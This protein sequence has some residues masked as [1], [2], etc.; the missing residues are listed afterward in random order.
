MSTY[1]ENQAARERIAGKAAQD[2]F[3]RRQTREFDLAAQ[4]TRMKYERPSFVVVTSSD[5]FRAGYDQIRWS[6]ESKELV[7]E[8]VN[9][10]GPVRE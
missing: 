1:A 6:D 4:D 7:L 3:L 8:P 5:A 9:Q 2:K 10:S